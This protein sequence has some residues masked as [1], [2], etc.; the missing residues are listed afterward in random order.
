[1]ENDNKWTQ[2]VDA[3]DGVADSMAADLRW[4]LA[5]FPADGGQSCSNPSL[6]LSMGAH[7]AAQIKAS[8]AGSAPGGFTPTAAAL[9]TARTSGWLDDASDPQDATRSKNVLLVTDGLPNCTLEDE[10]DTDA[11]P[12]ID[13]AADYLAAGV[14]V[15]VVGFGDG[16][17]A[18]IL[19]DI[20][21][22]GGTDNPAD[23]QNRYFQANNGTELEAALVSI[24]ALVVDCKLNLEDVPADPSRIYVT[25]DGVAMVRDAADGFVYDAGG[26]SVTL[27][28]AACEALKS[29]ASPDLQVV[30]GCPSDGGPPIIN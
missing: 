25:V 28:G 14:K 17:D 22:A 15:F 6:E 11:Q 20:A 23:A 1:M 26:N 9:T 19:N 10:R 24:G 29:S 12:A 5:L 8:Y 7:T 16:V 27:Q 2:A 4:G 18:D 21:E 13:A 30:F 3:L